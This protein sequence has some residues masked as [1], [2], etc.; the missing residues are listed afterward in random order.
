MIDRTR[1]TQESVELLRAAIESKTERTSNLAD[2]SNITLLID[3][4]HAVDLAFPAPT[5]FI[6]EHGKWADE[7]GWESIW[8]VGPSFAKRL[9]WDADDSL[10]A[11][12]P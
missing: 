7:Q 9:D 2:I 10:P 3:G 12:R 8:A 4:R 6:P 1:G 11:S 5:V